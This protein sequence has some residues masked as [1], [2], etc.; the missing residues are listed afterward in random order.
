MLLLS[1]YTKRAIG[2]TPKGEGEKIYLVCT[3]YGREKKPP[4]RDRIGSPNPKLF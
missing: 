4:V 3:G 2:H 1:L